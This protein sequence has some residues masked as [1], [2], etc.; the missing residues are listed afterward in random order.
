MSSHPQLTLAS[1]SP[2]RRQLIER[3]GLAPSIRPADIDERPLEDET[4]E[5]YVQRLSRDKATAVARQLSQP[6]LVIGSD[7]A[8]V[9][10]G[11]ILGKPGNRQRAVEMLSAASGRELRF[12][13]G[14]CVMP[15]GGFDPPARDSGQ[16]MDITRVFFRSLDARDI[17][18]YV[19]LEPAF[20]CAGGFRCEGL[21]ITLFDHIESRDPTALI[22]LPLIALSRML[23]DF[24]MDPLSPG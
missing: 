14:L 16:T 3:L 5:S 11:Q 2:Y 19:D 22:G 18:A 17:A 9:L 4:P 24:G 21:G 13:T 23:R 12:L 6:S 10:G 1:R 7:Q 20:D 15:A 8:A